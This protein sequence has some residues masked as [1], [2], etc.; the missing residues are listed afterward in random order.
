MKAGTSKIY[1][2]PNGATLY[3]TIPADVVMDSTFPF[4]QGDM[5]DIMISED[6][7]SLKV[8]KAK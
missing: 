4:M 3:I 8:T 7:K 5:V 6:H 2:H 1:K